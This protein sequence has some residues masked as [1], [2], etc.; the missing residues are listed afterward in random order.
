[1]QNFLFQR[2]KFN[3]LSG[4][5]VKKLNQI[6]ENHCFEWLYFLLYIL[7]AFYAS[8]FKLNFSSDYLKVLLAIWMGNENESTENTQTM[9][10]IDLTF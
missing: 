2:N 10:T 8:N 6:T 1:M 7:E 9:N 3:H 5:I 4:F